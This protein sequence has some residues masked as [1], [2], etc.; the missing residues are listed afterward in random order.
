METGVSWWEDQQYS[1]RRRITSVRHPVRG[2]VRDDASPS[3]GS[4]RPN[5]ESGVKLPID[6]VPY[7]QPES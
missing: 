6:P 2:M 7:R 5:R 1:C 4:R 3:L